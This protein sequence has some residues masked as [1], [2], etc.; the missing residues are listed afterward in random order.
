MIIT[1]CGHSGDTLEGVSRMATQT[2]MERAFQTEG[3]PSINWRWQLLSQV[4][5]L[6]A[7]ARAVSGWLRVYHGLE[8]RK[9]K[10]GAWNFQKTVSQFYPRCG[11]YFSDLSVYFIVCFTFVQSPIYSPITLEI[12]YFI[13]PNFL[14]KEL[15]KIM[16]K[17]KVL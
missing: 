6:G 12:F 4:W 13:L 9:V 7:R 14:G 1:E 5:C 3:S 17:N 8:V 10:R 15:K 2:C 11:Y 16:N